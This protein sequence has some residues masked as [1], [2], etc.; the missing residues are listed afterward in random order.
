MQLILASLV[1]RNLCLAQLAHQG[2]FTQDMSYGNFQ[3]SLSLSKTD[4]E[5]NEVSCES[6]KHKNENAFSSHLWW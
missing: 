1:Y 2:S 4:T 6:I 5:L 3:V